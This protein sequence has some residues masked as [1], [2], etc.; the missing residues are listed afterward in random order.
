MRQS[1]DWERG[2]GR[3]GSVV[4]ASGNDADVRVVLLADVGACWHAVAF[5]A[6][7]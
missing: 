7:S 6:F 3:Y 4:E 2:S 1:G 5:E